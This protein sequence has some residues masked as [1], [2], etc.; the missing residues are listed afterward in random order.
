M[1]TATLASPYEP[2]LV[3]ELI[4]EAERLNPVKAR[5]GTDPRICKWLLL[6]ELQ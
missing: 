5:F 1:G 6:G 4:E 3:D 2:A